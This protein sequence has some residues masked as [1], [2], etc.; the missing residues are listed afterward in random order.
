G[1]LARDILST[2][3]FEYMILERSPTMRDRQRVLLK[4]YPVTWI[5]ELPRDVTGCVFS[6]EF[7]DA[8]PVHRLVFRSGT[9]KEIYVDEDF[10]EIEGEL[11]PDV[12]AF[13]SN[14][15]PKLTDGQMVEINLGAIQWTRRIAESLDRGYHVAIDYGYERDE[16]YA[17]RNGT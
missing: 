12:R 17:K 6:N 1:L 15:M 5:D 11:Q 8:L 7:F 13:V 16:F 14:A 2:H 10:N 4:D 9:L 3:K